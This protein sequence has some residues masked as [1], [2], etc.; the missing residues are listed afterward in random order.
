MKSLSFDK[1][2][3]RHRQ[4]EEMKEHTAKGLV[5]QQGK[6][7][8]SCFHGTSEKCSNHKKMMFPVVPSSCGHSHM[9]AP[10]R[11]SPL[12]RKHLSLSNKGMWPQ[13]KE[14][15]GLE[16]RGQHI[17]EHALHASDEH[18]QGCGGT[19]PHSRDASP[20]WLGRVRSWLL[21]QVC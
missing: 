2:H 20:W 7:P 17:K 6:N 4:G 16:L 19:V 12:R 8:E 14:E 5:T 9:Q 13:P 15:G 1:H 21:N 10:A 11:S 3:N 18:I